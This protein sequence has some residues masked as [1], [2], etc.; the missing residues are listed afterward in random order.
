MLIWDGLIFV[1]LGT[2]LFG[3]FLDEMNF[4]KATVLNFIKLRMQME[5][6]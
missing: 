5:E 3:T 4:K 6:Y 1:Q 2:F